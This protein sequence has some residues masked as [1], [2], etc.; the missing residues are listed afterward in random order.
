MGLT[1]HI[2]GGAGKRLKQRGFVF[3]LG[4]NP[5]EIAV[6]LSRGRP[7]QILGIGGG[8]A[9]PPPEKSAVSGDAGVGEH[10][11]EGLARL[12]LDLPDDI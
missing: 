10:A 11:T 2:D 3:D 6:G 8:L 1:I 4:G 7:A 12:L 9:S 5:T